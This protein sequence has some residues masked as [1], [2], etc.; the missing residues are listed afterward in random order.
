MSL[1]AFIKKEYSIDLTLEQAEKVRELIDEMESAEAEED[2]KVDVVIVLD[3]RTSDPFNPVHVKAYKKTERGM[4]L[5]K[6]TFLEWIESVA[7]RKLT[8]KE[9][10]EVVSEGLYEVG[11]G[12]IA[13]MNT[14]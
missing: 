3:C 5:A 6:E 8:E 4:E 10:S 11:E 2:N 14:N 7:E 12:F 9:K 13:M 1:C